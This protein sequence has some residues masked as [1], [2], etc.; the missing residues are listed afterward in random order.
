MWRGQANEF[1]CTLHEFCHSLRIINAFERLWDDHAL[2]DDHSL[3][4]LLNRIRLWSRTRWLVKSRVRS[5]DSSYCGRDLSF[6]I[7]LVWQ[8][9]E[10]YSGDAMQ[11]NT[12]FRLGSNSNAMKHSP[13]IHSFQNLDFCNHSNPIFCFSKDSHSK[14]FCKITIKFQSFC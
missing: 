6:L 1:T 3:V 10:T 12:L 2:V 8:N 13:L 14:T 11:R 9:C 7:M 5:V 4:E